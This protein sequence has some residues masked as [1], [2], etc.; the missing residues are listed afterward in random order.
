MTVVFA[1]TANAFACR[2]ATRWPGA[3]GWRTNRLLIPAAAIGLLFSM[4]VL[5]IGPIAEEMGHAS[6]PLAGWAVAVVAAGVLLAVDALYKY[7]RRVRIALRFRAAP[8]LSTL[9]AV[10]HGS[11]GDARG[12]GDQER[13]RPR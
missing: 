4:A 11:G 10:E 3:L 13:C 9:G 5:F 12:G 1:Q 6:P 2:S 8:P 7:R